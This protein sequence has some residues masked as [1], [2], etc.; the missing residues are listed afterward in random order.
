MDVDTIRSFLAVAKH[1]SISKAAASL[2]VTQPAMS[3]RLRRLEESL[4]FPLFERDWTGVA[5]TREGSYF[6]PYAVQLVRDLSDAA[7]VLGQQSSPKPRSFAEVVAHPRKVILGVDN[8][9][10]EPS[11]RSVVQAALTRYELDD[12]Q[13]ITRPATTLIDLL[14][15]NQLDAA[16]FY[17]PDPE[18]PFLAEAVSAEGMVLIHPEGSAMTEHN[19]AGLRALLSGYRFVLFDNPVLKHHAAITTA[20]I[21]TYEITRF[22]VVDAHCTML[23]LIRLGECVTVVPAGTTVAHAAPSAGELMFTSLRAVLPDIS[24]T[25]GMSDAGRSKGLSDYFPQNVST[26]LQK[27]AAE[28]GC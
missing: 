15:L 7:E 10:S 27:Q 14:E 24:V 13:V 3:Q 23:S 1:G 19:Q 5:I 6:L 21:D 2:Y 12:I 20:L 25:V 8:W 9:L 28:R 22:H 16:L 4:G 26:F 11:V 18:Y 17:S